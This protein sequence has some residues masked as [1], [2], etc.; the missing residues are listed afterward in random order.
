MEITPEVPTWY[1]SI[2][3]QIVRVIRD[4]KFYKFLTFAHSR[5]EANVEQQIIKMAVEYYIESLERTESVISLYFAD[6]NPNFES[7]T[8]GKNKAEVIGELQKRLGSNKSA[9][10]LEKLKLD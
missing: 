8:R 2:R 4:F 3:K 7:R 5:D 1:Q 6:G 10:P 9:L